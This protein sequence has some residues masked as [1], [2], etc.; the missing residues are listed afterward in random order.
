[1]VLGLGA[2]AANIPIAQFQSLTKVCWDISY[3]FLLISEWKYTSFEDWRWRQ[4]LTCTVSYRCDHSRGAL[5]KGCCHQTINTSWAWDGVQLFLSHITPIA[6][7]YKPIQ[8]WLELSIPLTM[9][10]RSLAGPSNWFMR[11]CISMHGARKWPLSETKH[12]L[13][14]GSLRYFQA[15]GTLVEQDGSLPLY[16]LAIHAL[17]RTEIKRTLQFWKR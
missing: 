2:A 3:G 13:L 8:V 4:K 17:L 6:V 5:S 12:T 11:S 1:M 10:E 14:L 9:H 16:F 7:H 15:A